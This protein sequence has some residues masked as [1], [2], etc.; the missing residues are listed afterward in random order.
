MLGWPQG[1]GFFRQ[2]GKDFHHHFSSDMVQSLP[3]K[4]KIISYKKIN[5]WKIV[6]QLKSNGIHA[7][8]RPPGKARAW[9]EPVTA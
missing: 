8:S 2:K 3:L 9:H 1:S 5:S 7:T 6:S 4:S